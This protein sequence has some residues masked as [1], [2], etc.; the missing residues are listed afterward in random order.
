MGDKRVGRN[1]YSDLGGEGEAQEGREKSLF[2]FFF[3]KISICHYNV[4]FRLV[5]RFFK[6]KLVV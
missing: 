3:I 1:L 6:D 4:V 2:R 5:A